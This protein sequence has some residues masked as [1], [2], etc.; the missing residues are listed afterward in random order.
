MRELPITSIAGFAFGNAENEKAGTGCTTVVCEQGARAGVSVQGGS[1]GTRETDALQSENL[2]DQV[3]GVF[4]SGGS[5]FGLDAGSGVMHELEK[6]EI[7]FD[8][9][10]TKVPIVPGAILFDLTVGDANV[11]PDQ[12]MGKKAAQ[13]ALQGLPFLQGNAGAGMGA[14]VGKLLGPSTAM[15]GGLGHYA[16]EVDGLK[17]GAV[18]AVNSFG[19]I[20]DPTT[21]ER[22]AGVYDR[23]E[24]RFIDSERV[25]VEHMN[26]NETNRFSENTTIG[27]ITCNAMLSKP[28]A[29]KLAAIA[30]DGFARTIK[31]S[32]MFV[33]GDTLFAM[34]TNEVKVDLNA[35]SYLACYVVERAVLA[36]VKSAD[37]AYNLLS[38]SD[39]K[40]GR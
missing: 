14:S 35:L 17:I 27:I 9:G 31:P 7:G 37:S 18:I 2:I 22:M 29:N 33:D 20:V 38:Y 10:V 39:I 5:A 26:R 13:N 12:Q 21:G 1:P 8:V 36:A 28:Q 6:R 40:K 30:H 19:D 4:L 15:K 11:R 3:H 24:Q 32:H 25:L 34:T 23:E 16:I